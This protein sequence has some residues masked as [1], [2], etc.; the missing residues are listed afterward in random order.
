MVYDSEAADTAWAFLDWNSG[1]RRRIVHG[2]RRLVRRRRDVRTRVAVTGQRGASSAST[3]GHT[4]GSPPASPAR[5]PGSRRPVRPDR[6]PRRR[7]ENARLPWRLVDID[8]L[9]VFLS[10]ATSPT[11]SF[12]APDLTARTRSSLTVTDSAGLSDTD[13]VTVDVTNLDPSVD[14]DI[15]SAFARGVTLVSASFTDPGWLDTHS[16]TFNWGARITTAGGRRHGP[17]DWLGPLLRPAR[18]RAP[19]AHDGHADRRRR[20]HGHRRP[21][22]GERRRARRGL[23]QQPPAPPRPS[24]DRQRRLITGRVHPTAR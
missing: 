1:H 24:S 9:P 12:V 5:P 11:P 20:G 10:S 23:G 8:G 6:R 2:L 3:K 7:P 14:A 13:E 18:T 22:P 21:R 15:G 4:S 17:G 19:G 16:A